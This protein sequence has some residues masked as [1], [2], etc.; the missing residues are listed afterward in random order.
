MWDCTKY[1]LFASIAGILAGIIFGF[2]TSFWIKK[3]FN[4]EIHVVNIVLLSCYLVSSP[5][6][7]L[8]HSLS[9]SQLYF[10]G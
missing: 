8:A 10:L 5:P 4:D 1:F 3:I 9:P 7:P 2:I 6:P